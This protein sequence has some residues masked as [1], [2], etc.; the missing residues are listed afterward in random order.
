MRLVYALALAAL[1]WMLPMAFLGDRALAIFQCG[2]FDGSF[3][4]RA[5][6]GGEIHGKNANPTSTTPDAT[7]QAD[8]GALPG[9]ALPPATNSGAPNAGQG[10]QGAPVEYGTKPGEHSCPPGYKVLAVPGADGYRW[11]DSESPSDT[12]RVDTPVVTRTGV[13][14]GTKACVQLVAIVHGRTSDPSE[15]CSTP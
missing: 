10:T 6:P 3:S 12:A 13:A 7:P 2:M 5:A 1:L 9:G 4:C 11:N 15:G 14:P 8:T